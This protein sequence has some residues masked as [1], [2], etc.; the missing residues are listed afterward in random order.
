MKNPTIPIFLGSCLALLAPWQVLA[1]E[2]D[3][4]A[5]KMDPHL[6]EA[7]CYEL[8][9]N[10]VRELY[11][12]DMMQLPEICDFSGKEIG[13]LDGLEYADQVLS[14]NLSHN[15]IHS[16]LPLLGMDKLQAVSV[17]YNNLNFKDYDFNES[18]ARALKSHL[19]FIDEGVETQN[20]PN[21]ED[22]EVISG[23]ETDSI[24]LHIQPGVAYSIKG[25][26]SSGDWKTLDLILSS[27]DKV[28]VTYPHHSDYR[29]DLLSSPYLIQDNPKANPRYLT[30]LNY[31]NHSLEFF[32]GPKV[33]FI[34]GSGFLPVVYEYFGNNW[35]GLWFSDAR[36]W[37]HD[38]SNYLSSLLSIYNPEK[39]TKAN[40]M[41]AFRIRQELRQEARLLMG[42]QVLAQS[43]LPDRNQTFDEFVTYT[44]SKLE[45]KNKAIPSDE[46][47]YAEIVRSAQSSNDSFDAFASY[48]DIALESVR[49]LYWG[50]LID[51][52]SDY[53]F[54]REKNK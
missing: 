16:L 36:D 15:K 46:E 25:C 17:A 10:P 6:Q 8:G 49:I 13:Y 51:P 24:T 45:K 33:D 20:I 7:I 23:P 53:V 11:P 14:L 41:D 3:S 48:F 5:L 29:L 50:L 47:V 52:Q 35:E 22:I 38:H 19:V 30:Y 2:S 37:Y 32:D 54:L 31:L 21:I 4:D 44:R 9:I 27:D 26:K 18:V 39:V 34:M 12:V 42:N 43:I 28:E 1:Q 40:A